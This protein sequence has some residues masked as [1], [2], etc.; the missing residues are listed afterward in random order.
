MTTIGSDVHEVVA[1]P[2]ARAGTLVERRRVE[3]PRYAAAGRRLR[4]FAAP[5]AIIV[6]LVLWEV[7]SRVELVDPLF[8]PR[9]TDVVGELWP[10][11]S[12]GELN[13]DFV[14][15]GIPFL[16]GVLLA[17][18]IGITLGLAMG[19]IPVL[20]ASL[21]PWVM[22]C[23][24]IPRIAL[25]PMIIV[26]LGISTSMHLFVVLLS[27]TF[28]V[29]LNVASGSASVDPHLKLMA[30]SFGASRGLVIRKV[31]LPATVPFMIA[32][33]RLA[34]GHALIGIIVAELFASKDG[35]GHRL[36]QAGHLFDTTGVYAMVIVIAAVGV[37]INQG[38]GFFERRLSV[39]RTS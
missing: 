27:A 26:I 5:V 11:L 9:F 39:W 25:I 14:A 15:S 18:A 31:V 3:P 29:L 22:I 21:M 32:G 38:L 12:S 6:G 17:T 28:P 7:A 24:S 2:D 34:L 10:L 8:L 19:L 1:P 30:S 33:L 36:F 16:A 23:N 13:R 35:I 20:N 37:L 4:R